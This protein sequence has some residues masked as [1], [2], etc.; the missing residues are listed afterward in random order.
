MHNGHK[1]QQGN[2]WLRVG[3]SY[4]IMRSVKHLRDP[5]E[6]EE[7]PSFEIFKIHLGNTLSNLN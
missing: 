6:S 5:R 2:F 1:L 3:V 4:F 7:S